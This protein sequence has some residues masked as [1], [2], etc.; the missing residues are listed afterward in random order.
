MRKL[1]LVS[2]CV[3]VSACGGGTDAPTAPAPPSATP[4]PATRILLRDGANGQTV[5]ELPIQSVGSR[6]SASLPGYLPRLATFRGDDVFLWP[7]D[8]RYTTAL[9][10]TFVDGKIY[11]MGRWANRTV[12][13]G[14]PDDPRTMAAAAAAVA[15]AARAAGID[16]TI[17]PGT[18]DI[19]VMVD[20]SAFDE[21][22]VVA[23]AQYQAWSG[24]ELRRARIVFRSNN[25]LVGSRKA[26][27]GNVLLHELGHTLG[28]YGHSIVGG[29]V[30]N[31]ECGKRTADAFSA[32]ERLA[33]RMM[34]QHRRPGNLVPDTD[35][36]VAAAAMMPR[37]HRIE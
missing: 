23:F 26:V 4:A 36:G 18:G 29:E 10:Y 33:L 24:A 31:A 3:V 11:G 6:L 34:Y 15:E 21:D 7:Q 12:T 8:E 2:L 1:L 35:F 14:I 17:V 9:I 37:P 16:L 22:N 5:G 25:D 28:F 27:C 13:V 30:M 32:N 20:A 19:T